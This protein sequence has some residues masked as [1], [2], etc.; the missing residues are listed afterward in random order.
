MVRVF[1]K[2]EGATV[3][4]L[5]VSLLWLLFL[6]RNTCEQ[7]QLGACKSDSHERSGEAVASCCSL[8]YAGCPRP[9]LGEDV[10]FQHPEKHCA[11]FRIHLLLSRLKH[12]SLMLLDSRVGGW[13]LL[14]P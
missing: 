8:S 13:P 14:F 12:N 4:R 6:Q 10:Y 5:E 11:L 1:T 2:F 3:R 7:M 9:L